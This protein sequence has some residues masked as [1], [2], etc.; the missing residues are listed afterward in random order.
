MGKLAGWLT[1]IVLYLGWVFIYAFGTAKAYGPPSFL[2]LFCCL[3]VYQVVQSKDIC[4]NDWNPS[5]GQR[6]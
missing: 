3:A 5:S 4:A 6:R 2:M 1:P